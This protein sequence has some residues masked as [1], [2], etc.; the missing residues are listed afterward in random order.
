MRLIDADALLE[1]VQFRTPIDN[2]NAEVIA[3]CVDI[4]RRIIEAQ[5]TI[6]AVEVVHGWWK[7]TYH[8]Y[9]NRDG[10]CE[11]A[12]EWHCSECNFYSRERFNYCQNC[13]AR[14]EAE[15]NGNDL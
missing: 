6:D 5:P 10:A 3:G 11:I 9:Y 12:D 13:G 15:E 1:L 2:Q 7:P 8:T 4:T 14:M